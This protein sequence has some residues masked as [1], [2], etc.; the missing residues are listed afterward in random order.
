MDFQP[1]S[2]EKI[3]R[4]L[5]KGVNLLNPGTL[6][7]GDE[8]NIDRISSQDVKIYPGCRIYGPDTVISAGS[9]IGAEAPATMDN[10]RLGSRV[11]LKGGYFRE[12]VFLDDVSLGSGAHVREGCI[13][14]EEASGAHSVGLKQTI[15]FPFVTLGSLINFC[16]CL[17]AGGT[18]RRQHSEVGSSYIHFNFTPD[19][20]KATPSLIGDV[21]RGVMLN[22]PPVFLGGQGG[23]V[24]PLRIGFG[25]VVAA[26]SL[27][28]QDYPDDNQL[29]YSAPP[30]AGTKDFIPAAYP[31]LRRILDNNILYLA[32]IK[33]LSAWYA[34][35]R[36]PF[37]EVQEFGPHLL[38]GAL[39]Q[40]ARAEKERLGRLKALLEKAALPSRSRTMPEMIAEPRAYSECFSDIENVFG[41][42]LR[43]SNIEKARDSFLGRITKPDH[44]FTTPY[45]DAVR[46]L[47]PDAV[48]SGTRWLKGLVD[49]YCQRASSMLSSR[50]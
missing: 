47:P 23:L 46:N 27:L 25:N 29:I 21:P 40:L 5:D 44:S 12:S 18:S 17:M 39:A 20:D 14:E 41:E 34:E 15:L 42:P 35:V 36:R 24:G 1:K 32:S 3:C 6:D 13:L 2:S 16:D 50:R 11:Q 33:A 8:V 28:R 30:A 19:G 43:D 37:F 48:A 31:H 10:C 26:G 22:Q 45:L 7:I 4:L 9:T 49:Y 38:S